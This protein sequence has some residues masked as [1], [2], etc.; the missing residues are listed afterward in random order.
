MQMSHET[1]IWNPTVVRDQSAIPDMDLLYAE[2]ANEEYIHFEGDEN[3]LTVMWSSHTEL[4][5]FL[6]HSRTVMGV[7]SD[8]ENLW[9]WVCFRD[10]S[11][12]EGSPAAVEAQAAARADEVTYYTT[13]Y[14]AAVTAWRAPRIKIKI[15]KV[16]Y[17]EALVAS[18]H[19]KQEQFIA[20]LS[21]TATSR[22]VEAVEQDPSPLIR[23]LG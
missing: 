15:G 13:G 21:R 8:N 4:T 6:E 17:I 11:D 23:R 2:F 3:G 16:P 18:E 19:P 10:G 22:V 20:M 14:E 12:F 5:D 7:P 9:A 1:D